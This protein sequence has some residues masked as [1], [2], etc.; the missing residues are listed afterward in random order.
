VHDVQGPRYDPDPELTNGALPDQP[1]QSQ[2]NAFI[3]RVI[4]LAAFGRKS[5]DR[6]LR[7]RFIK[8]LCHVMR[9]HRYDLHMICLRCWPHLYTR[10]YVGWKNL[11]RFIVYV[12]NYL[13]MLVPMMTIMY[14]LYPS[15]RSCA[16]F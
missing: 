3:S 13:R 8:E 12:V 10:V 6:V 14:D 11:D 1:S 2:L 9:S 4:H 7:V 16:R 5:K 15:Y